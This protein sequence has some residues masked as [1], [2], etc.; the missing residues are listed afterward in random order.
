[1]TAALAASVGAVASVASVGMAQSAQNAASA[2][3]QDA[4]QNA[5][6]QQDYQQRLNA[7]AMQRAIASTTDGRG[8]T[9]VYDPST[10]SWTT[11]LSPDAQRIQSATDQASISRNTTDLARSQEANNDAMAQAI[12]ARSAAG[13]ALA[14][15]RNFRP[16]TS[17]GMEGALQE[18]AT[19]ANRQ[20]QDPIIADT[21]RAFARTGTAAAPVLTNMMRD[22]ATTLRTTMLNNKIGAMKNVGDINNNNLAGLM[23]KYKTLN[24]AGNARL[25]F[26]PLDSSSPTDA[27]T[28]AMTQRAGGASG[29][30]SQGAYSSALGSNAFTNAA[31]EAAKRPFY[32]RSGEALN[33]TGKSISDLAGTKLGQQG[34]GWLNDNVFDKPAATRRGMVSNSSFGNGYIGFMD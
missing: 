25:S 5:K 10:N 9:Q 12:A 22:N 34:I 18:T 17:E 6:N 14:E 4:M 21:L 8:S 20:A 11:T 32:D 15:L 2:S 29:P 16:M 13:P 28:S 7:L 30:A 27:L 26:S 31:T 1:M 33:A 24:E 3:S 23:S 19:T